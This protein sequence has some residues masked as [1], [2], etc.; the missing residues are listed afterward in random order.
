MLAA[1]KLVQKRNRENYSDLHEG[2]V[3]LK[4]YAVLSKIISQEDIIGE[5]TPNEEDDVSQ[6]SINTDILIQKI[7]KDLAQEKRKA[8]KKHGGGRG[9]ITTSE[10]SSQ[11]QN[12]KLGKKLD[13]VIKILNT[14]KMVT[15]HSGDSN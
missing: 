6:L 12:E 13:K 5:A 11:D 4:D 9:I 14:I 15:N 8:T 10:E 7:T 1:S 2:F 3:Q